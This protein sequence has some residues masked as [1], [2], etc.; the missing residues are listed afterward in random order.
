VELARAPEPS[1]FLE[2]HFTPLPTHSSNTNVTP[3]I[4]QGIIFHD[5]LELQYLCHFRDITAI[6]LSGGFSPSLWS[7]VVLQACDNPAIRQL[8]IATAAMSIATRPP[9]GNHWNRAS[10][11]H[12]RYALQN[13]GEALKGVREM[14][15]NSQDST[16]TT[17]ISAL[18][19]FCFESLQE[20]VS[21]TMIHL[22]SAL[23][24]IFKRLS[25]MPNT[26]QFPYLRPVGSKI[27]ALINDELLI[28]FMRID[29]PSL[30]LL[31]RQ[32]GFPPL[33]AGR[34]FRL[35]FPSDGFEIPSTFTVIEEARII[36]D[37]L[38]WRAFP[39]T[40]PPDS[41]SAM[42]CSEKQ[43]A[44]SPDIS[45]V[46]WNVQHWYT[47][48][49]PLEGAET[50]SYRLALWHDAFSPLLNFAM[51][52][53]GGPM[54]IPAA[55][56]HVQALSVELVLTGFFPPSYSNKRSS[57]FSNF[58]SPPFTEI[59][60]YIQTSS[61]SLSV[62]PSVPSHRRNSLQS[63]LAPTE[64]NMILFPTVHAILDF[65]CRLVAH[66]GFSKG[67]VFDIGIISSLSL[68]VMLCP[69]RKLRKEAVKVLKSMR[70]RR[71]GVW[72]S[73][74]CAEAGE[75][76]I[77]KEERESGLHVIDPLLREGL[78]S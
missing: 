35:V 58:H 40:E 46:P 57:S 20:D 10:D 34:I 59:E 13:Y 63:S 60:S 38:K 76:S 47:S 52:S 64:E 7:S 42:W 36:L 53:A 67:F 22:Q 78:Q 30:S 21:P 75:K 69:D 44:S 73:R 29:R 43:E 19:I 4:P 31:C 65:T 61:A 71:E 9:P 2:A 55:I 23:E 49:D 5:E 39:C 18:L 33:P 16:R 6:E 51:T 25:G 77:A 68:V 12:H 45:A 3:S 48:Y 62:P 66:P 15:A 72:D 8:T 37:D 26:Y 50:L 41:M 11:F 27:D 1:P 32:K 17:L 70:P 28:A 74:V 14:V 54:F 24:I 56:L